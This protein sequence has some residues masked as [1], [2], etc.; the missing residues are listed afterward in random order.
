MFE[1]WKLD[2][3]NP[4]HAYIYGFI[5]SDGH[6][7]EGTRNRG[8]LTIEL[9]DSDEEILL[10]IKEL[11]PFN[12][13]ISYRTRD[14]NFKKDAKSVTLRI[15]ALEFRQQLI[16]VGMIVGKKSDK[17]DIPAIPYSEKDFWRGMIDGDGSV[18][19]D[20]RG[21]PIVS[22]NTNSDGIK[23]A[24]IKFIKT[25]TGKE[26]NINRNK[27]DKS[28]NIILMH[29]DAQLFSDNMYYT[30]C[31]SLNRK[32]KN[33]LLIMDWKRPD[34]IKKITW[35]VRKW[36]SEQDKI[37]STNSLVKAMRLTGR[38][39]KAIKMRLEKLNK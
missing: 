10:K 35:E 4:E 3:T 14:T 22:L 13:N 17:V 12:S 15:C 7:Q 9:Q 25:I 5:L 36:T 6:L 11:L 31:L 33:Y 19:F 8:S 28:Y 24:Y 37:I 26:K 23:E 32:Y 39:S 1:H 16:S 18:G 2:L 21:V 29:E 20:K 38:T 30:D 34:S 27:R